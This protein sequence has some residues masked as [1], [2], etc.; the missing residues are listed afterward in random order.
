MH[1]FETKEGDKWV[2]VACRF[3][4]ADKIEREKWEWLFDKYDQILRCTICGH[5]DYEI[6]D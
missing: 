2:C 6:E 3:E 1:L 4:Q 5:P